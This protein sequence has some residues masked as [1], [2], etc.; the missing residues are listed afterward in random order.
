MDLPRFSD[1]SHRGE[2][3]LDDDWQDL[4]DLENTDELSGVTGREHVALRDFSDDMDLG[5]LA[6]LLESDSLSG[7]NSAPTGYNGGEMSAPASEPDLMQQPD[8]DLAPPETS[9]S[10]QPQRREG[11]KDLRNGFSALFRA[12]SDKVSQKKDG[13]KASEKSKKNNS[14]QTTKTEEPVLISDEEAAAGGSFAAQSDS[15]EN[16]L[17]DET[18]FGDFAMLGNTSPL[19]GF[20]SLGETSPFEAGASSADDDTSSEMPDFSDHFPEAIGEDVAQDN[21]GTNSDNLYGEMFG[22][23]FAAPIAPA[24]PTADLK[25]EKK[26]KNVRTAAFGAGAAALGASVA[27]GLTGFKETVGGLFGRKKSNLP[28]SGNTDTRHD[29]PNYI[30]DTVSFVDLPSQEEQ[31]PVV[32]DFHDDFGDEPDN[33]SYELPVVSETADMPPVSPSMEDLP[34]T[35]PDEP[36]EVRD[37]E[38]SRRE[39]IGES[40]EEPLT[41][42]DTVSPQPEPTRQDSGVM[43]DLMARLK[44]FRKR[45]PSFKP[46]VY[47]IPEPAYEPAEDNIKSPTL[48]ADIERYIEAQRYLGE[49]EE[50]YN[51]MR[52]FISTV[53]TEARLTHEEIRAPY[54]IR[55]VYAAENE[56]FDLIDQI[57]AQNEQQRGRIGVYEEA[58][59]QDPYNYRGI[60]DERQNYADIEATTFSMRP[61]VSFETE[62]KLDNSRG[63]P[64]GPDGMGTDWNGLGNSG[65][66][67]AHNEASMSFQRTGSAGFSD[68]TAERSSDGMNRPG[69]V[70]FDTR[71]MGQPADSFDDLG[72]LDDFDDFEQDS[73]PVPPR[74]KRRQ[75]TPVRNDSRRFDEELADDFDS[76]FDMSHAA[77]RSSPRKGKK[78]AV[79]R[80]G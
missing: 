9:V 62:Q 12:V 27:A 24:E 60:N 31:Q 39:T 43:A 73:Q 33:S 14:D 34:A 38:L 51:E 72:N 45:L 69:S 20:A 10:S 47:T 52:R 18:P 26:P 44:A 16:M 35:L 77:P 71:G 53:S 28:P 78:V 25:K 63:F 4:G 67:P 65:F 22:D 36:S 30:S 32:S 17:T 21:D 6:D 7:G 40:A 66:A 58:P 3:P 74:R 23:D 54:N 46:K 29:D 57:S 13:K 48:A 68:D 76:H 11:D 15:D 79:R 19:E 8:F 41:D 2:L 56:L 75:R 50:E 49:T 80:R 59:E 37:E 61:D 42:S 70:S 1:A 5:E 55:E 64:G